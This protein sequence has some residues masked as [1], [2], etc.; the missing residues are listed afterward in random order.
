MDELVL[1]YY[2]F[3][4]YVMQDLVDFSLKFGFALAALAALTGFAL[5][6]VLSLFEDISGD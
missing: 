6:K 2:Y 3:S 5:Y 1:V 4:N